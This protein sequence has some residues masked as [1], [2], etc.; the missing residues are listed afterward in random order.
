MVHVAAWPPGNEDRHDVLDSDEEQDFV[1]SA[2][3]RAD[4]DKGATLDAG[5]NVSEMP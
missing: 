2:L 1:L 3:A 5:V 4:G